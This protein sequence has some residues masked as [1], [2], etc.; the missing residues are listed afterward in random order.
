MKKQQSLGTGPLHQ[1]VAGELKFKIGAKAMAVGFTDQRISAHAG[2]AAFWGWLHPS[3]FVKVLGQVLPHRMPQSNNHLKPVE[4]AVGFLQGILCEA[5]KLTHVAYLRRD[6]LM[7][8]LLG[9]RRVA[10]QSSLSRFFAG[11][12]GAASNVR[13]FR[14]LWHW[15]MKKLPGR[16]E[17]YTLD[18]DSTKLLHE[19][20]HQ[21]GVKSG[22]TRRGLKP[23][24]HPLLGVLAEARLVAGF[25]LRSGNATCASNA[26]SFVHDLLANLPR[27]LR[28][29]GVRADAGFCLPELLDYFE[30]V[31]LRYVVVAALSERIQSILRGD[32]VWQPTEVDGMEVAEMNFQSTNWRHPRRLILIRHRVEE[33]TGRRGGKML[34]DLPQYLFQA[35]VTS[36]GRDKDA[37]W[38]WRHYNGR[39]D[40]ENVIKELQHGFGLSGL[41]C[42]NFFATEAA[43]SLAVVAYNLTVLFQRHLGWQ[44]KVTIHS[45]RFWLFVTG[46][47]VSSPAGQLTVKLAVPEKERRWWNDL[48]QKIL[49]PHPNCHAVENRPAFS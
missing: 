28:L 18:L 6:E 44:T 40:C 25:W 2:T 12:G 14:A 21:Q 34:F 47:L 22:Y 31:R 9:I 4:K 41:I 49:C 32:L 35:L 27:H 29:R 7:P 38:I 46:G 13:C 33:K 16:K 42:Q 23:C 43:L 45:L 8:P 36:W 19:D 30:E 11:F 5:R 17:G 39:A 48:W 20:G 1:T 15:T 37:L 10:S 3:G 26:L 24:L